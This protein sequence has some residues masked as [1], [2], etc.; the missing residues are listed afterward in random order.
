MKWQLVIPGLISLAQLLSIDAVQNKAVKRTEFVLNTQY[1]DLL[2]HRA[3]SAALLQASANKQYSKARKVLRKLPETERHVYETCA[4]EARTLLSLAKCVAS[5]LDRRD[6]LLTVKTNQT[7]NSECSDDNIDGN[8]LTSLVRSIYCRWQCPLRTTDSVKTSFSGRT[9]SD[10]RRFLRERYNQTRLLKA[11]TNPKSTNVNWRRKRRKRSTQPK[12][13]RCQTPKH[14]EML[15]NVSSYFNKFNEILSYV[16]NISKSNEKFLNEANLRVKYPAHGMADPTAKLREFV[17]ELESYS[18]KAVYSILSPKLLNLLPQTPLDRE[19]KTYLSPNLLSFQDEGTLSLPRLLQLSTSNYCET[20]QW[21]DILIHAT[22][23]SQMLESLTTKFSEHMVQIDQ[24]HPRI[25]RAQ[26][27]DGKFDRLHQLSNNEQLQH[28]ETHG[29]ARLNSNQIDLVYGPNGFAENEQFEN[30][31][32]YNPDESTIDLETTIRQIAQ[33]TEEDFIR[34][35]RDL[36]DQILP[37]TNQKTVGGARVLQPFAFSTRVRNPNIMGPYIVSPYAFYLQLFAPTLLSMELLSPRAFVATIFSPVLL[38]TRILSPSALRM[39]IFS[40]IMLVSWVMVP[41]SLSV[42][43]FS[44]KFLDLRLLSPDSLSII[45]FSPAAAVARIGSP[46]TANVIVLS[47]SFATYQIFSGNRYVLS[48][49]ILGI[50]E[51]PLLKEPL[52]EARAEAVAQLG[53]NFGR[54]AYTLQTDQLEQIH[55]RAAIIALLKAK[56]KVELKKLPF[57]ETA[58]FDDCSNAAKTPVELARCVERLLNE[59]DRRNDQKVSFNF[60]SSPLQAE[61]SWLSSAFKLLLQPISPPSSSV[62]TLFPTRNTSTINKTLT[63]P[64]NSYHHNRLLKA[65]VKRKFRNAQKLKYK[66]DSLIPTSEIR[67]RR[68]LRSQP[69]T[70]RCGIT[71]NIRNLREVESYFEAANEC[72]R[73][74]KELGLENSQ[75]L[76]SV[77]MNVEYK[78]RRPSRDSSIEQLNEVI[79]QA[80]TSGL[81]IFSPKIL[82][83]MPSKDGYS[84]NAKTRFMSPTLFSLHNEG[85]L[86]I[87]QLLRMSGSDECET[88]KWIDFIMDVTGASKKLEKLLSVAYSQMHQI[89]EIVL[90]KVRELRRQEKLWAEL[91]STFSPTQRRQLKDSGYIQMTDDQLRLAYKQDGLHQPVPEMFEVLQKED[92]R[93]FLLEHTIR[94]LADLEPASNMDELMSRFEHHRNRREARPA[95]EKPAG[96]LAPF[97]FSNSFAKPS[98]LLNLVLSPHAFINEVA[99]ARFFGTDIISP[100]AFI[101]STLSPFSM[102]ARVLAPSSFRLQTLTPQALTAIVLTPEAFLG[103]I[104]SPRALEARVLSPETL[105]VVVLSPSAGMLRV[106]SPAIANIF[107]LSPTILGASLMSKGEMNVEIL[108]PSILV[109]DDNIG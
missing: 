78:N 58:L 93:D 89:R 79:N 77:D 6:E 36:I 31:L 105:S 49:G 33:M 10:R 1:L 82:N 68:A 83:I 66:D 26:K 92:N 64:R 86:P 70:P 99:S 45:C 4:K 44:P 102:I 57:T 20:I 106:A 13:P 65:M 2:F 69:T 25:R 54:K 46:N 62:E 81:S 19:S 8:W 52:D 35:K 53:E 109:M 42:K 30:E 104:L 76:S 108:S 39:M 17:S 88:K 24:I 100:R 101:S 11:K 48:P 59:R 50:D 34:P 43:L 60:D 37:M 72:I 94:E 84:D 27:Y 21:L 56:A 38:L 71:T 14:I 107:V 28:L 73:Y 16:Y 85:V 67:I 40:P 15:R 23:A 29:Y 7:N 74:V 90:P 51:K 97:A 55:R 3:T 87:P 32:T 22:G 5:V 61:E 47:P 80:E 12:S 95:V 9:D 63:T 75:F 41:E 91:E 18:D 96:L 103:V 98:F